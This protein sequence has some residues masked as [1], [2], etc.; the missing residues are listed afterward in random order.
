MTIEKRKNR[1]PDRHSPES[2]GSSARNCFDAYKSSNKSTHDAD[3]HPVGT[4]T[5]A[6][7]PRDTQSMNTPNP[8]S[9][10]QTPKALRMLTLVV[11]ILTAA[12][13]LP[14]IWMS[15][16]EF[17]G[18]AWG[19]FGFELIVLLGSLMTA[20][21]CLGKV[22]V[23]K[24]FPLALLCLAGTL[25]VTAVFGLYVDARALVGDDPTLAPWVMR[26]LSF[27]LLVI[28]IL[29]LIATLDV[30]RRDTRSWGLLLRAI[31]FLIPVGG[32]MMWI[33]AKGLPGAG[34]GQ[35]PVS[36][37][38]ILL[39]GLVLGILF[40]ISGHFFIRSYEIAFPEPKADDG[41]EKTPV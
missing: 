1:H 8:Q 3:H 20:L 12:S 23:E 36:M 35:S 28:A 5:T 21:V 2:G 11:S 7:H 17:G 30:F 16:G 39:G 13:T 41:P 14:W 10:T 27:R 31:L 34:N 6:Y 32:A 4:R 25:L 26:T 29:S 33:K 40:T 38:L 22:Q 37:I 18:F 15:V 24:A 19:L 9:I